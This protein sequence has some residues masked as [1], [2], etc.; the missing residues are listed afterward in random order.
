MLRFM[1]Y[2]P[3]AAHLLLVKLFQAACFMM[4]GPA[5]STA[6]AVNTDKRSGLI[7]SMRC[8]MGPLFRTFISK[9]STWRLLA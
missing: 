6:L 7:M 2:A 4:L 1:V 3:F 9:Y 5:I 8:H